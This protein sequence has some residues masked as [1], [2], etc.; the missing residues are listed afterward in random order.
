M[1]SWQRYWFAPASCLDLAVVRLIAVA[2]QLFWMIVFAS[3]LDELELRSALPADNWHPLIILNLLNL[4]WG[5]GFRPSFDALHVIY[6]MSLVA[7]F[8]AL[9]G[10]LTNASLVVFAGTCTYLQAFVYSFNDFHHPEAVMMVALSILA[11]SPSGRVLSMDAWLVRLRAGRQDNGLLTQ[12]SE[13][14]GW[15][16]K[17]I[18]WFFVLM[19]ASA[20]WSKLSASG[21]DWANGFT[22]QYVLARDALRWDNPL[23]YWLSQHH[24]LILL[25]QYG[26]LLF[27]ATFALAVIFRKLRWIYVPAGLCLHIGIY[28]TLTAPFFQWIAL[29]AVFI[30]WAEALRLLQARSGQMVQP[31][32]RVS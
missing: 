5:W 27:Q 7:G 24:I 28:L 12:T 26:V 2:T 15:P 22:L 32:S 8:L 20:V 30:P 10:F 25:A 14:A 9:I 18:Q 4:P 3:Q 19:Y 1:S 6:Y 13:F 11:L 31:A 23:G 16:I 29:Y 21:L 17:L